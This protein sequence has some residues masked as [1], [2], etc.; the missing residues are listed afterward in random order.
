MGAI[1]CCIQS[2]VHHGERRIVGTAPV[3][4]D[5]SSA[6]FVGGELGRKKARR[7]SGWDVLPDYVAGV[8]EVPA[9]NK[10]VARPTTGANGCKQAGSV[11]GKLSGD[12]GGSGAC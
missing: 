5:N 4:A 8:P 12:T 10:G 11:A 3:H 2:E 6:V 1:P 9:A 7:P